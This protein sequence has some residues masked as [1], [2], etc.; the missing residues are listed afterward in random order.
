MTLLP[1]YFFHLYHRFWHFLELYP[2]PKQ[3]C[4]SQ[5]WPV[6]VLILLLFT[7]AACI[8]MSR[9]YLFEKQNKNY[10]KMSCK[11]QETK[12][13]WL[14]QILP[15]F[16]HWFEGF[17]VWP[18]CRDAYLSG[19]MDQ[20]QPSVGSSWHELTNH[21]AGEYINYS[22]VVEGEENTKLAPAIGKPCWERKIWED[23]LSKIFE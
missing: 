6:A 16:F 1:E 19:Y 2:Q 17:P 20:W 18:G 21:S 4:R 8:N 22:N 5:L 11:S 7:S 3:K 15:P 23:K 9:R 13:H 10:G 12:R 14:A